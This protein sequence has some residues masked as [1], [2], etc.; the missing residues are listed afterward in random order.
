LTNPKSVDDLCI[1]VLTA[2]YQSSLVGGENRPLE[3]EKEQNAIKIGG[4]VAVSAFR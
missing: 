1:T 4:V 3:F 2:V